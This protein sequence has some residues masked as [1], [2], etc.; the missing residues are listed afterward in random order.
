MSGRPPDRPPVSDW[1]TDFDILDP[2]WV[3]NP[4]A[5]WDN[6]RSTCP[7]AHT[8]RYFGAYMPTRFA[9]V[10]DIAYDTK[11]FSSQVVV[12]RD[13]NPPDRGGGPPITSD[14]PRHRV[15]RMA[16]LPPFAPDAV[17]KLAPITRAYCHTL[18]DEFAGKGLCDAGVDFAQHI[19]VK[20]LATMLDV[21]DSDGD[22]FRGWVH[23]IFQAGITDDTA[24]QAAV[25][26]MT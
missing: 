2:A 24:M 25:E 15:A 10:R 16:L 11:N 18:I 23:G 7:V 26:G 8:E 14:P 17:A 21:P 12:L 4:Y 3:E 22:R 6:L 9:D 13:K 20:V 1:A 5:I 19:P